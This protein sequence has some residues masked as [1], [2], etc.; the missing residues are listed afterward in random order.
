M[1]KF[2]ESLIYQRNEN[3]KYSISPKFQKSKRKLGQNATRVGRYLKKWQKNGTSFMNVPHSPM[4]I[5]DCQSIITSKASQISSVMKTWKLMF[6]E[7]WCFKNCSFWHF[8]H[9]LSWRQQKHQ[10]VLFFHCWHNSTIFW[11][12][13]WHPM[14]EVVERLGYCW[15]IF[16]K[17]NCEFLNRHFS[18]FR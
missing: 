11:P 7:K 13:N 16:Y 8:N 12:N 4:S 2:G 10:C 5:I 18:M 15:D 1:C 17:V 14:T 9:V 3:M 6:P